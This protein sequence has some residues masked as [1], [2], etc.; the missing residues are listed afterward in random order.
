MP[1]ARRGM[2]SRRVDDPESCP[3]LKI[4]AT[5][6]LEPD[7]L[8]PVFIGALELE[9]CT[10]AALELCSA[11]ADAAL[12]V[13]SCAAVLPEL[14]CAALAALELC[15]LLTPDPLAAEE[16]DEPEPDASWIASLAA[17]EL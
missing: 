6:A 13:C 1:V 9:L 3:T 15:T 12:D 14:L 7:P 11:A 8:S 17:L 4:D 16:T 10:G 5:G 2:F